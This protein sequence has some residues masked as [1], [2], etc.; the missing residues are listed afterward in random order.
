MPMHLYFLPCIYDKAC[1]LFCLQICLLLLLSFQPCLFNGSGL[2]FSL[3]AVIL[4]LRFNPFFFNETCFLFSL[5]LCMILILLLLLFCL[6]HFKDEAD[7]LI[8]LQLCALM[9]L[10]FQ[11]YFIRESSLLFSLQP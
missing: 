1:L 11:P 8:H 5:R 10:Y 4:L 2:V 7:P 9:L 6:S 3:S